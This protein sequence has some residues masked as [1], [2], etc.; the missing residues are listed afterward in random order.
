MR[1]VRISFSVI[2]D[3]YFSCTVPLGEF[4]ELALRARLTGSAC[5]RDAFRTV[6][7]LPDGRLA[8]F[9]A[10]VHT[11]GYHFVIHPL[12]PILAAR[13]RFDDQGHLRYQQIRKVSFWL[14]FQFTHDASLIRSPD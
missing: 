8:A 2:L 4:H 9:A 10:A 11:F 14:R 13:G 6:L 5:L 12:L 7:S 1:P 3:G